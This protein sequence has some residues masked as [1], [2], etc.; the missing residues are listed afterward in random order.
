MNAPVGFDPVADAFSKPLDTIDVS[1]PALYRDD[2][3][4]P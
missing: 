4:H 2:V 3:W 1:D